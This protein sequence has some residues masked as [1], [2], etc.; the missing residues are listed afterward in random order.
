MI[1]F[2]K[3]EIK[4]NLTIEQV[5]DLVDELGGEGRMSGNDICTFRTICHCGESHKLYYYGNSHLFRC[6]TEC[7]DIGAFDI[8]QLVSK[9]KGKD[10]DWSLP[11]SVAFVANYF[12][13]AGSEQNFED[14]EQV[15]KDWNIFKK[16]NNQSS[17]SKD[18]I[19]EVKTFEPSILK[20]FP[21]PRILPWEEEGI[22]KAVMDSRGICFDP[23]NHGIVI[24]HFDIDGKLIGIRERTLIKEEEV[25]GKYKPAIIAGKMYN[26]PLS[27][28]LYN[29]NWSKNNIKA[30]KKAIVY[31][32]EKS[33]LKHASIFGES[34]DI[35]VAVCGSNLI[36]YQVDLLLSLGVEEIIIAFDRQ[37]QAIG[38]EEFKRWTKKLTELNKKYSS[39]VTLSFMFDKTCKILDYKDSP[40]DKGKEAFLELFEG[41]IYL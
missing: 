8:F 40:I 15:L 10:K 34:N 5:K 11:K 35:S 37:Y 28:A 36:S 29:L 17:V 3:D 33:C 39:Y 27:F 12:G 1:K 41:R 23:S 2:D 25:Y 7:S 22:T 26:H 31:E 6:Y 4:S 19:V 30:I 21:R 38:D 13:I 18:K 24:P 14:D 16:Y 32:S 20:N 9:V